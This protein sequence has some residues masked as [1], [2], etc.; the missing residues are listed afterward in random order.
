MSFALWRGS[1]SKVI[2]ANV[3]LYMKT[4]KNYNWIVSYKSLINRDISEV[5]NI[6]S[7]ESNLEL[8]HPFCKYMFYLKKVI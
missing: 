1:I 4:V 8:F 6:I 5:W 7:V 3:L 2:R